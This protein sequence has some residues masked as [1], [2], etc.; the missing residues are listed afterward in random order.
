MKGSLLNASQ[1]FTCR[2]CKV[3]RTI[4]DWVNTDLHLNIGNRVSLEKVDNFFYLGDM[5]DADRGYDSAVAAR[6]TS[7]WKK[8]R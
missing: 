3:A 8:A 4:T 5:L 2:S 7:A 1:L 6:I